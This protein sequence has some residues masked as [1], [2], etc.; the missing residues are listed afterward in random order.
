[1]ATDL[2]PEMLSASAERTPRLRPESASSGT[3]NGSPNA[4]SGRLLTWFV[5][6]EFLCQI[7]LLFQ[8][9]VPLRVILRTAPFAASLALLLYVPNYGRR[10][11]AYVSAVCAIA[12][13]CLAVVH[14]STNSL[15]SGA[16]QAAMYVAILGPLF[17]APR[18]VVTH[19]EMQ[20]LIFVLWLISTASC[21]VGLLQVYEPD[22]FPMVISPIYRTS[23]AEGLMFKNAFGER[24]NRPTGLTDVPGGVSSSGLYAVVFAAAIFATTSSAI[25]TLA[26][27]TSM[28]IGFAAIALS[29]V[30][31]VFVVV[32]IC[33][34]AML[35]LLFKRTGNP[36]LGRSV[37]ANGLRRR[38]GLLIVAFTFSLSFGVLSGFTL[39]GKAVSDRLFTLTEKP[40]SDVYYNNRGI[41]LADAVNRLLPEYPLGA[42]LGR[43]GMPRSYFGDES[44]LD[45]PPI[46]V[47]IQ[48]Q[49]W[50][51]DG[52]VPL[53]LAYVFAICLAVRFAYRTTL[54][55]LDV[56]TAMWGALLC[57]DAFGVIAVCFDYPFFMSQGAMDFW[58]LNGALFALVSRAFVGRKRERFA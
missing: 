53:I 56:K 9:L 37:D 10:H 51:I 55:H 40:A 11:P 39:G 17:W 42:G 15:L 45:S 35:A 22:R 50:L 49:A 30:R 57:A 29:Q 23:Q 43:W 7:A 38:L 32:L 19:R 41:F 1:V 52:G 34:A 14:P 4:F 5:I 47:E 21:T 31:A 46:W 44:N 20:R 25:V 27:V 16:A 12:V 18:L 58:L 3:H 24:V 54:K 36:I 28:T 2:Q 6:L 48:W 13:V 26:L 8:S 33:V